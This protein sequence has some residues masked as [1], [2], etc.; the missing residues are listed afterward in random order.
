MSIYEIVFFSIYFS[1]I[2]IFTMK[3]KHLLV[4]L[5]SLES[6]IVGIYVGLFYLLSSMNYEFLFSLIFLTMS[7]CE[8]ALG[9]SLLVLMVR[10]HGND[11]IM[12]FNSLW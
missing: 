6:S 12:T 2:L 5:L 1:S 3:C 4:M 11:S 7:V 8:G 9:L 10:V